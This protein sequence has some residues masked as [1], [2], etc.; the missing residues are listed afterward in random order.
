MEGGEC[1]GEGED[2]GERSGE[3]AEQG[4]RGQGPDWH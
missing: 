3:V 4:E 1:G 2:E